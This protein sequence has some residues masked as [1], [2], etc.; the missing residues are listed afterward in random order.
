VP[1][2]PWDE[3]IR[4]RGPEPDVELAYYPG[5][6]AAGDHLVLVHDH[7]R[8][9]LRRLGQLVEHVLAGDLAPKQARQELVGMTLRQ[10]AD[11]MGAYCQAYCRLVTMHHGIEDTSVFPH[12][13]R[14]DPRLQAVID[15]LQAEH[16]IV[17]DI[18]VSVDR[19]LVAY[20]DHERSGKDL[21]S[22]VELL[23]SS[24]LSHLAYEE[25]ELVGPLSQY[26]FY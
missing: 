17:H 11:A 25:R 7:L 18:I 23:S 12:L 26:G 24:L 20:I 22:A 4:P 21:R 8:H 13:R 19:A 5:N 6:A 15:R 16:R 14:S 3:A 9:E 10:G 2:S 1:P